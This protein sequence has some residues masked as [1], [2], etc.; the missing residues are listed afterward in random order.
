MTPESQLILLVCWHTYNPFWPSGC[1]SNRRVVEILGTLIRAQQNIFEEEEERGAG[2]DTP[3]T[4][5]RIR[6]SI[7]GQ[8]SVR[9]FSTAIMNVGRCVG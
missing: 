8:S 4:L 1:S 2:V 3:R 5:L 9:E 7:Q 6:Y